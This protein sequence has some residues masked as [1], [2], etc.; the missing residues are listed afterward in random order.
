[1][2]FIGKIISEL[3]KKNSYIVCYKSNDSINFGFLMCLSY[4]KVYCNCCKASAFYC[5]RE[6]QNREA[7][8]IN[9]TNKKE[10]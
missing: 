6:R 2:F 7:Q 8:F 4:S 9:K 10:T 5:R 3:R 1:M